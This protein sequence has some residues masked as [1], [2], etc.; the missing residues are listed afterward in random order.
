MVVLDVPGMVLVI[1]LDAA[2]FGAGK[3][4]KAL[5]ADIPPF[6]VSEKTGMVGLLPR[7]EPI[8]SRESSHLAHQRAEIQTPPAFGSEKK[9]SAPLPSSDSTQTLPP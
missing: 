1:D 9:N 8:L 2:A 6:L 4:G 5:I 7:T 3:D